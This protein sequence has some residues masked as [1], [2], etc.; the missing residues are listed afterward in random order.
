MSGLTRSVSEVTRADT[1]RDRLRNC[2][3]SFGAVTLS[4]LHERVGVDRA[5]LYAALREMVQR[6]DVE[7]LVP[8]ARQSDGDTVPEGSDDLFYYRLVRQTDKDYVWEK[9]LYGARPPQTVSQLAASVAFSAPAPKSVASVNWGR[10]MA[11]SGFPA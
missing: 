11:S 1:V 5:A 10:S 2:L 6:G 8:L 4:R 9:S 3:H 7:V